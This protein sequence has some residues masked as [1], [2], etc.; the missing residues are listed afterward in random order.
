MRYDLDAEAA[1]KANAS[2]RIEESGKYIGTFTRAE[3]VT[4]QRGTV[5]IEFTFESENKQTADYLTIWTVN[6]D[7]QRIYGYNILMAIMT[8]LKV[9]TLETQKAT[10]NK[11]DS[12]AKQE[13]PTEAVI[14]PD[15]MNKRIGVLLQME[16]Y[17]NNNGDTKEKA[18]LFAPFE[19]DTELTASEILDKKVTPEK[20][21][22]MVTQLQPVKKLKA[23][24]G[25]SFPAGGAPFDDDI[26][27]NQ[28]DWRF[29][30]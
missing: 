11:W 3:M 24:G 13:I 18:A 20:L 30:M 1:K 23:S 15:L 26:P 8:C 12:V 29:A 7:N 22:G 28:L 19:A 10:I 6:K 27:F 25:S 14:Y 17:K 5:G 9:R 4:S 16:E 2:S 21:L